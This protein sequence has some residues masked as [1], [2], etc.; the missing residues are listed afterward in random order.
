MEARAITASNRPAGSDLAQMAK[1]T[2]T[3]AI[4]GIAARAQ[5]GVEEMKKAVQPK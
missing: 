4:A 3:D 2:H 5:Q 1:K